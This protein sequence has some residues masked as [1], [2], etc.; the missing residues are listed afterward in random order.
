MATSDVEQSGL[1]WRIWPW[2][3]RKS[4]EVLLPA[5]AEYRSLDRHPLR[6]FLGASA[7]MLFL[8]LY[9]FFFS[10]FVPSYFAFFMMPLIALG[11]LV[12]WALPNVDWAPTR[13]LEIFFYALFVGLIVWPNYLALSLPGLP[14]IT[15]IRLTSFPLNLILL[16]CLSMSAEF[17]AVLMRS[18]RSIPAIPILLAIFVLIQFLSIGISKTPSDSIQ[19]FIVAQTTWT[20]LFF[21]SAYVFRR[22]NQFKRWAMIMWAMAIFVSFIAI[23][24]ARVGHV[25][26]LGHIPAILKINDDAVQAI[27]AGNM[28]AYTDI[29]RSQATFST[30]LGLAEYLALTLPFILHFVT[31]QFSSRIRIAAL[32]SLPVVLYACVLTNSKLGTIGSLVGILLYIFGASFRNW[33]R[34]KH[35]LISASFLLSYPLLLGLVGAAML[36]SHRVSVLILGNDGS[37]AASTQA[38]I[39]QYTIGW[40]KFL[41][42]PFGYGIGMAATTLGFGEDRGGLT[43]DTYYLS[44]LLEYGIAGF[45]VYYGMF[46]IAIFEAGRRSLFGTLETEDRTFMLPIAVSLVVFIIIKSVFSQQ[47]NHPVVFMMLGGLMALAASHRRAPN[48]A[49]VAAKPATGLQRLSQ[50]KTFAIAGR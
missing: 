4:A 31:R 8:L 24:E 7:L 6:N 11:L 43:I 1:R 30:S 50:T 34:N 33:R 14:W 27:L 16:A 19:K 36:F 17:R 3:K 32:M 29:Y 47:D 40:H 37:H 2:R 39:E 21:V 25:L 45:I 26:W 38:R 9:G 5:L 12:I 15:L 48:R 23:V 28:R 22:P 46:A 42:W 35:S 13:S 44:V 20:A 18:L 49:R 41:Q 10:A